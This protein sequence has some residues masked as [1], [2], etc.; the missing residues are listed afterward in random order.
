VFE[1]PTPKKP[2]AHAEG[3]FYDADIANIPVQGISMTKKKQPWEKTLARLDEDEIH[4]MV[5]WAKDPSPS[6]VDDWFY[7]EKAPQSLWDRLKHI[8]FIP[9][10]DCGMD[11]YFVVHYS[12][13]WDKKERNGLIVGVDRE[14][15]TRE[16][17]ISKLNSEKI[18]PW[19]MNTI[20]DGTGLKYAKKG[21]VRDRSR[22][23]P[24]YS[25][26]WN[27]SDFFVNTKFI[28]KKEIKKLIHLIYDKYIPP[29]G[30]WFTDSW[31]TAEAWLNA[32][33]I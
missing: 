18:L 17:F 25:I 2:S 14:A 10:L 31:P 21:V 28:P 26:Y 22:V 11:S 23:D 33:G 3:F 20:L 8:D 9:F 16:F 24:D 19:A 32:A 7:P 5:R 29:N 1:I 15:T 30:E 27:A 4:M 12:I 6:E 13:L